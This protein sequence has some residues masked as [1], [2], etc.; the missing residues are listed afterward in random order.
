MG[1]QKPYSLGLL[2]SFFAAIYILDPLSLNDSFQESTSTVDRKLSG[3]PGDDGCGLN[4]TAEPRWLPYTDE[5]YEHLDS[6][7]DC[8]NRIIPEIVFKQ[9]EQDRNISDLTFLGC[10]DNEDSS[11]IEDILANFRTIVMLGDSLVRQQF[12]ILKCMLEPAS[13]INDFTVL[14][15]L[16][17]GT[18][19]PNGYDLHLKTKFR[20][21]RNGD[22]TLVFFR[23]FGYLF[24]DEFSERE[25][26]TTLPQLLELDTDHDLVSYSSFVC[27]VQIRHVWNSGRDAKDMTGP[28]P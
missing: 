22:Y 17:P 18:N 1:R 24:A 19:R 10:D 6:V 8:Y 15:P 3:R 2:L 5:R 12:I 13:T 16:P 28:I 20:K 4:S 14:N 11:S 26:Y 25:L 27:W 23:P 9:T 21:K 7:R